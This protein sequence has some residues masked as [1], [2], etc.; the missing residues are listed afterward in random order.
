MGLFGRQSANHMCHRDKKLQKPQNFGRHTRNSVLTSNTS[1]GHKLTH[2]YMG[3][4]NP[5]TKLMNDTIT[6]FKKD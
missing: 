4:D 1:K 2:F 3:A 5:Y 6:N